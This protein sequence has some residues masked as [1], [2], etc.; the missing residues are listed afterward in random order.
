MNL[1][2]ITAARP[3]AP[4]RHL[5]YLRALVARL[6][7][8]HIA[9]ARIEARIRVCKKELRA[10]APHMVHA[11][12]AAKAIHEILDELEGTR[13][14]ALAKPTPAPVPRFEALTRQR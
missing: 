3:T 9:R 6:E 8:G 13:A 1:K 10:I 5:H 14:E 2:V 11:A 7:P 4:L 12:L